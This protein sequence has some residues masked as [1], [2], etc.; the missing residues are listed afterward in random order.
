VVQ[1][2]QVMPPF[3]YQHKEFAKGSI[4][5]LEIL[6][7]HYITFVKFDSDNEVNQYF[8]PIAALSHVVTIMCCFIKAVEEVHAF[9]SISSA[10]RA[11]GVTTFDIYTVNVI[12]KTGQISKLTVHCSENTPAS[13]STLRCK[14]CGTKG[15]SIATYPDMTYVQHTHDKEPIK[16]DLLTPENTEFYFG[17]EKEN[18][19]I[20]YGCYA[21]YISHFARAIAI[22]QQDNTKTN[23]AQGLQT[24]V[25]IEAIWRSAVE[26]RS[27]K[28]KEIR[29]EIFGDTRCTGQ[30]TPDTFVVKTERKGD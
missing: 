28:I 22:N 9:G 18:T 27:I 25:I 19:V 24:F 7:A 1:T 8:R 13:E 21:N 16:Y 5:D 23:V 6:E 4:G 26:K 14:L 12:S 2:T 17:K 10:A 20:P 15:T 29:N 30:K 3:V 11:Q